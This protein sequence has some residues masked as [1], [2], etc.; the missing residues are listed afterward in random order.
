MEEGVIIG[1]NVKIGFFCFVDSKVE[2]GEGI[3]LLLY[4]V[5]K[6][7]IKIGCFNWIF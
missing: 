4:V 7:L 1:V 5:V 6:G 3:E 2:I